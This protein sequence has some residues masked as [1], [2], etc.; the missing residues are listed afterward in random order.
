MGNFIHITGISRWWMV[1]LLVGMSLVW[2]Q[3]Q[4]TFVL[5]DDPVE[6]DRTSYQADLDTLA[7]QLANLFPENSTYREEF[8]VFDFGFY[9]HQE[10]VIDGYPDAIN[11]MRAIAEEQAPYYLLFGKESN[12]DGFY[13]NFWVELKLPTEED[14]PCFTEA[15]RQTIED[16]IRKETNKVHAAND[17]RIYKFQEAELAGMKVLERFLG[18]LVNCCPDN[19]NAR[20]NQCEYC[21]YSP[22]QMSGILEERGMLEFEGNSITIAEGT[23]FNN[24]A[25]EHDI[26]IADEEH[27]WHL[28]KQLDKFIG[29]IAGANA[30]V[31]YFDGLTCPNFDAYL[32]GAYPANT[33]ASG[34][35]SDTTF[36]E[37]IIILNFED[38]PQ[39]F[40]NFKGT[41]QSNESIIWSLKHLAAGKPG[42]LMHTAVC[43]E[44]EQCFGGYEDWWT[45]W[46]E[47]NMFTDNWSFIAAA[48]DSNN[49]VNET[50][51]SNF[52]ITK[53]L[54]NY[55]FSD[56][57]RSTLTI[58]TFEETAQD[59]NIASQVGK[60]TEAYKSLFYDLAEAY[61]NAGFEGNPRDF[62]SNCQTIILEDIILEPEP[63]LARFSP[64]NTIHCLTPTIKAALEPNSNTFCTPDSIKLVLTDGCEPFKIYGKAHPA[65]NVHGAVFSFWC[66]KSGVL[67]KPFFKGIDATTIDYAKFIGYAPE[68]TSFKGLEKEEKEALYYQNS[69]QSLYFKQKILIE[70]DCSFRIIDNVNNPS[71]E[72][73]GEDCNCNDGCDHPEIQA[74]LN[75]LES[76]TAKKFITERCSEIANDTR[77]RKYA[78]EIASLIQNLGI[79]YKD[80]EMGTA[81]P[82]DYNWSGRWEEYEIYVDALN[83]HSDGISQ[84]Y[85]NL[86]EAISAGDYYKVYMVLYHA[87]PTFYKDLGVDQRFGAIKTLSLGPLFGNNL[88]ENQEARVLDLIRTIPNEPIKINEFLVKLKNSPG[89]LE[90]LLCKMNN[91]VGD[92]NREAFVVELTKLVKKQSEADQIQSD[93]YLVWDLPELKVEG[94]F[95]HIYEFTDND[96]IIFASK[97]CTHADIIG[98]FNDQEECENYGNA[99]EW[100][101]VDPFALITFVKIDDKIRVLGHS[102]EGLGEMK[103]F[104]EV[105]AIF[106]AYAIKQELSEQQFENTM[107]AIE[108]AG[109]LVGTA[110]LSAA[111][112]TGS[113]WR[114]FLAGYILASDITSFALK[115]DNIKTY[116]KNNKGYSE[117]DAEKLAT[118]IDNV[119][120]FNALISGTAGFIDITKAAKSVAASEKLVENGVDLRRME[121]ESGLSIS[122]D[123]T[124]SEITQINQT[125]KDELLSTPEGITELEKA[126]AELST[127]QR[128]VDIN[129]LLSRLNS[130]PLIQKWITE[131]TLPNGTIAKIENW[132][133]AN[134]TD[135]LSKLNIDFSE[136]LA[137]TNPVFFNYLS[138]NPSQ[139]N[140]YELLT[141][142][143]SATRTSPEILVRLSDDFT[144]P[145]YKSFLERKPEWRIL[146]WQ[147]LNNL[148]LIGGNLQL[149]NWF[150]KLWL[151]GKMSFSEFGDKLRVFF[152]ENIIAYVD[153]ANV[154]RVIDELEDAAISEVSA[155]HNW[156][157]KCNSV[158]C[159][160]GENSCFVAGTPVLTD[161][162][163][164]VNIEKLELG[165]LVFAHS[166]I[167]RK[168][169]L[170]TSKDVTMLDDIYVSKHQKRIDKISLNKN[171]WFKV[172]LEIKRTNGNN[173]KVYLLRPQSW[174]TTN[175]IRDVGDKVWLSMPEQG[176]ENFATLTGL[177]N[178]TFSDLWEN[179]LINEVYQL[180]PITGIF[181]HISDDI[182]NVVFESGDTL[183]VTGM[184]PIY[185]KSINDW[186]LVKDLEVGE[187][188]MTLEGET[189]ILSKVKLQDTLKVYNLEVRAFHNFLVGNSNILVHNGYIADWFTRDW[190][191][192][193]YSGYTSYLGTEVKRESHILATIYLRSKGL[194][195]NKIG[196]VGSGKNGFRKRYGGGT[197]DGPTG[198]EGR[199]VRELGADLEIAVPRELQFII[200][201]IILELNG[202]N[203]KEG[204]ALLANTNNPFAYEKGSQKEEIINEVKEWLD[205]TYPNWRV[206]FNL[207]D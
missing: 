177:S 90:R 46:N 80:F 198:L 173:S 162:G 155:N 45:A 179:H 93:V 202:W 159:R 158:G 108:V 10:N 67:Y 8:K 40:F 72:A 197:I 68:G 35:N 145:G 113:R 23:T 166:S 104:N 122:D 103:N 178:F 114:M 193:T 21:F 188:V 69:E 134:N 131:N 4:N 22:E 180:Q 149:T 85:T 37:E 34:R 96:H 43:L 92:D 190:P 164:T 47:S 77:K 65:E 165:N 54:K 70:Q 172:D 171:E 30:R 121:R 19:A 102:K 142:L 133:D 187:R 123:I 16:L 144:I 18:Q 186:Q 150:E 11:Q 183:G 185:S 163:I 160:V 86:N 105:P 12:E 74:F 13:Q 91:W 38:K 143:P 201:Q 184:H 15:K 136:D 154:Q 195:N 27:T 189:A 25:A 157:I 44:I 176:I 175:R 101:A 167:N 98:T 95:S 203:Q 33:V 156:N 135:L 200:E 82:D 31:L 73:F 24:I 152:G 124:S 199:E 51:G 6:F 9:F 120:A 99:I 60:Q 66:P 84:L 14:L 53:A 89:L 194:K 170:T 48:W 49:G 127:I 141:N 148:G 1:L 192:Y 32:E 62:M 181:E 71:D 168:A 119:L 76:E 191:F 78:Y 140:S 56:G 79:H 207:Y 126:R 64:A 115:K 153:D 109:I 169:H 116:L 50:F 132:L 130:Y 110:E 147:K 107:L 138:N 5:L 128:T 151:E 146:V 161:G 41:D 39:V 205:D 58:A 20:N 29:N 196:Y 59:E 55:L 17:K 63:T 28:T 106:A 7:Q 111:I 137:S 52:P 42:G 26:I 97:Q 118:Y 174:L 81:D 94:T 3:G 182:W 139:I 100:D 129:D 125:A 204:S 2:G 61:P 88:W 112:R 206:D 57:G 83:N 117:A 87:T 36:F 75:N